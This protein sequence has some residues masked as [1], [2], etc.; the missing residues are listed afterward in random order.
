MRPSSQNTPALPLRPRHARLNQRLRQRAFSLVE[1]TVASSVLMLAMAG[2]ITAVKSSL[3][4]VSQARHL[5]A[6]SQLMQSE[7]E[8]LRLNNWSQLQAIQD[9]G[10]TRIVI[11]AVPQGSNL[12]CFRN[13]R[14]VRDGLKEITLEARWGGSL[15]RAQTARLVTRYARD[16][17]NDYFYTSH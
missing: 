11:P 1:V 8:R 6:A 10:D 14:D 15:D 9:S 16:G 2:T 17:L 3:S 5:G 13:I 4:T 7:L 12:T